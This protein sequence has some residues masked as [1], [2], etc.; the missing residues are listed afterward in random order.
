MAT[1]TASEGA[2]EGALIGELVRKQLAETPPGDI[3]VF[4][5]D[6]GGTLVGACVFTRLVYEQDDRTVFVLAPVAVH[7]QY[8][9]QGIGQT[10]LRQA[11]ATLRDTRVDVAM[12]YGDPNYYQKL[13]FQPVSEENAPAPYK[14]QLPHGWMGQSL[15]DRPLSSLHGPSRCVS[16]LQ[17]PTFW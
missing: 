10:L 14:L 12:T 1:F 3:H 7:T 4:T 6:E 16:A 15:T 13:G 17:N 9:G 11:L 5:A 8:Q 2:A